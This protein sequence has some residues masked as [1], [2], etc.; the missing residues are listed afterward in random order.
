MELER[1]RKVPKRPDAAGEVTRGRE[2]ERK[3]RKAKRG[4]SDHSSKTRVSSRKRHHQQ[5]TAVSHAT[6]FKGIIQ[7]LVK[8]SHHH[9]PYSHSSRFVTFNCRCKLFLE[10]RSRAVSCSELRYGGSWDF[11][12]SLIKLIKYTIQQ[13]HN[14]LVDKL[15][16]AHSPRYEII[17]Y[18][19]VTSQHMKQ[20]TQILALLKSLHPAAMSGM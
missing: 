17:M 10:R 1:K 7:H 15:W 16:P 14:A 4:S 19:Y 6:P 9:N 8:L 11:L 12:V 2:R 5:D 18:F 3:T 20:N 13:L